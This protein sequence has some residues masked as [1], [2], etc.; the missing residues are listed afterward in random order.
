MSV[1]ELSAQTEFERANAGRDFTIYIWRMDAASDAKVASLLSKFRELFDGMRIVDMGSGTGL[2]AEKIAEKCHDLGFKVEVFAVDVSHEFYDASSDQPLIKLI[3]GDASKPILPDNSVDCIYFSTSGHEIVSFGGSEKIVDA[4]V[5]AFSALRSEG[6]LI[7]RDFV[8]PDIIGPIFMEL[9]HEDGLPTNLE[10]PTENVDYNTLSTYAKFLRFHHEFAGGNAF[11][12]TESVIEGRKL[13]QVDA[14]WAYEFYMRKEYTGNW[15]NEIK[16][17][18]SYWTLTEAKE[19]L[20]KAGFTEVLVEADSSEYMLSNWLRGKIGLFQ[21]SEDNMLN[22]IDF[23]PTHMIVSGKKP[24]VEEIEGA[25]DIQ[26]QV[27]DF[28]QL[29]DSIE[30]NKTDGVIIFHPWK[31]LDNDNLVGSTDSVAVN[32]QPI[33]VGKKFTLYQ[34]RDNPRQVIKIPNRDYF[35]SLN[36]A[37][38]INQFKSLFQTIDRQSVLDQYQTAHLAVTA[39]DSA[40]PPYR[41]LIQEALPEGSSC[42]ASFILSES[43][44]EE[45]VRQICEIINLYE[46]NKIYQ[47]DTNPFSWYR[48]P[49][50]DGSFRL[51]YVSGK[52]YSYHDDWTFSQIGLLQWTDKKYIEN[53]SYYSAA[54][55]KNRDQIQFTQRWHSDSE[56]Y[57]LW[58]KY[59]DP[60]LWPMLT[61]PNL[62]QL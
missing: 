30:I 32:P 47:L 9:P 14:E 54:I 61:S 35:N 17:K 46:K 5:C 50:P 40:G 23:P 57:L 15:R 26:P 2:V 24:S 6:Q 28:D 44:T 36:Y 21:L 16:E 1:K 33:A 20:I 45:D 27:V 53:A 19:V 58:K 8:K 41:Y 25:I 42:L 48:V 12:F 37:Q 39:T 31:K 43:L 4:V 62:T 3:Y 49:Q 38:K 60:A 59:L 13:I 10:I 11:T 29:L 52:V 18:Y 34:L 56:A 22:A 7:I 51:T 55:P